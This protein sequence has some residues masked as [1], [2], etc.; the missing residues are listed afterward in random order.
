RFNDEDLLKALRAICTEKGS[1]LPTV[2]GLLL[3]GTPMVLKRLFPLRNRVDYLL[4][5]GRE[6]MS[7]SSKPYTVVEMCEALITGI[8]RLINQ[9]MIDIPQTFAL[10]E[11]DLRRKDNPLIPR[12]VIREALVNALMH[13][14]YRVASPV[15]I[16]KY[17]NRT[18]FRN[19]G[20]SLKPQE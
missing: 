18:E 19:S 12:K 4:V 13:R 15:Q 11:D 9:I 20:Y 16:I 5:E 7:D 3:F 10:E 17:A 6:W 8:P 1:T 14:D 2:G